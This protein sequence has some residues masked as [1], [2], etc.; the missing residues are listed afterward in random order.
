MQFLTRKQAAEFL[1]E[2]GFPVAATTLQKYATIGGGPEYQKFGNR[3]L[4]K[5]EKLIK[6]AESR[7]QEPRHN[8]SELAAAG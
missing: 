8:T 5:P 4:Y 7:I 6:W 2:R 1:T 3:S